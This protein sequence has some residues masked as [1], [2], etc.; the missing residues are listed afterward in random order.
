MLKKKCLSLQ[1]KIYWLVLVLTLFGLLMSF[2]TTYT[3]F[4]TSSNVSPYRDFFKQSLFALAG[5]FSISVISRLPVKVWKAMALP[6]FTASCALLVLV[7]I[8]PFYSTRILNESGEVARRWLNLGFFS[9]Q[10]SELV[11]FGLILVLSRLM[12]MH[13]G[14]M[15]FNEFL[16]SLLILMIPVVLVFVE[17]NFSTAIIIFLL[18]LA[19]MMVGATP[20]KYFFLTALPVSGLGA[21]VLFRSERLMNRISSYQNVFLDPSNSG[22]QVLQSFIAISRGSW[23]GKGFMRS[24]QKFYSLPEAQTDFVY[25][26]I[27]EEFGLLIGIVV[28]YLYFLLFF[29]AMQVSLR[30][31]DGFSSL[32][33]A[34]IGFHIFLQAIMHIAVTIGF[35]PPTGIPLP[36]VSIGG[37]ALVVYLVEAGVLI[38]LAKKAEFCV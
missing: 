5:F 7:L 19:T 36:F 18:G 1:E 33:A 6:F 27:C 13:K 24:S 38:R 26:I 17:P 28:L 32:L 9:F 3:Y 10:P 12:T 15:N 4:F 31:K 14:R 8:P 21:L 37:T 20:M 34:M 2:S 16:K 29:W 25:S 35:L 30:L 23:L 11:K 22:Y